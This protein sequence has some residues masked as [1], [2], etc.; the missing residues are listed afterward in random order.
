[1]I[2]NVTR[3]KLISPTFKKGA[4]IGANSTNLPG[5]IIGEDAVVGSGS[6][7]TKDISTGKIVVG[8]PARIL[9]R[10]N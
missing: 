10:K 2:N 6:V 5:I 9:K 7:V 4:R 8:N 1:M 3:A